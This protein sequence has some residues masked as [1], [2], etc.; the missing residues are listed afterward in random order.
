MFF[1]LLQLKGR[2]WALNEGGLPYHTHISGEGVIGTIGSVDFDGQMKV[3]F[4]A[5]PKK[6]PST[7]KLYGYGY[8]VRQLGPKEGCTM[9]DARGWGQAPRQEKRERQRAGSP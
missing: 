2:L 5:H 4:T 7:G 8:Q 9:R 1:A 6:D 3:P